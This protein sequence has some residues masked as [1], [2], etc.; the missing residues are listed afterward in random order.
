MSEISYD[1][2]GIDSEVVGEL[3]LGNDPGTL[4]P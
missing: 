3:F 4:K 2:S 1:Q